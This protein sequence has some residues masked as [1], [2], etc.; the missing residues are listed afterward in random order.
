MQN[1]ILD[2]AGVLVFAAFGAQYLLFWL[3]QWIFLLQERQ[4]DVNLKDWIEVGTRLG[5]PVAFLLGLVWF[6]YKA[7]WP[8]IVKRFEEAETARKA[9]IEKFAQGIR[10][11]N[12]THAAVMDKVVAAF[13][14]EMRE[15][16]NEIIRKT[17]KP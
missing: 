12:Q 5:V 2:I 10:E 4:A 1:N 6:L 13:Q 16:R 17:T 7:V 3:T 15:L 14:S 9:E 8:F 11:S